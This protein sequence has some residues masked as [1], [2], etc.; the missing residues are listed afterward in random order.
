M[1]ISTITFTL[2]S[3]IG[4]AFATPT[5]VDL[6]PRC[7]TTVRPFLLQRLREAFP[8]VVSGNTVNTNGNFHVQ[9]AV[10]NNQINKR[11]YQIVAFKNIPPNS[12]GCTLAVQFPPGYA[13]ASTGVATLNVTTLYKDTPA[14]IQNYPNGYSWSKFFP[15]TS[16]P[17]GQGLFGTTTFSAG[18]SA[19]INSQACPP[20][21][22]SMAFIFAISGWVSTAAS[23]DF[24]QTA[25]AGVYLTFNC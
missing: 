3:L 11:I 15:P 21:G 14:L 4:L 10:A 25:T 7:G 18:Q 20:G 17:L 23:V 9:Q 13:I 2:L 12:Y 5:P 8:N 6:V 24:L 1:Q 16:P 19:T 22:G